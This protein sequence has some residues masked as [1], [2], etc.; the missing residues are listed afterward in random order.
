MRCRRR[1]D[2]SAWGLPEGARPSL[3]WQALR[4]GRS[5]TFSAFLLPAHLPL[6]AEVELV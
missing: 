3:S 4:N 6:V 2:V 5:Y 1:G